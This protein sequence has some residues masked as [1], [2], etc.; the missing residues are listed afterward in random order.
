MQAELVADNIPE[1]LLDDMQL[2]QTLNFEQEAYFMRKRIELEAQ[3]A[4][5]DFR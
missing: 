5:H 3:C 4:V 1:L 2:T